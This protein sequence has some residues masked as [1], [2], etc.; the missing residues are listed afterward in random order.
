MVA[1]KLSAT[2]LSQ[3]SPLRPTERT[4]P[5]ARA[6]SAKSPLVYWVNSI[7]RRNTSTMEVPMGRPAGWMKELTGR[8][9]MKSPGAP[10]L[11]REVEQQFW[12]QIATGITT[13]A[14]ASTVGVSPAVGARWFRHRGGMP[15][16]LSPTTGRYLSF[17]EREEIAILRAQGAGIRE[18][19]R[20]LGR[21]PSTISREL[22]RNAAT[23]CGSS[24]TEH[25]WLNGRPS[26]WPS[27]QRLRSS[28]PTGRCATTCR[29]GLLVGSTARTGLLLKV[30]PL[31]LGRAE[32]SHTE[33]IVAG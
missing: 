1:K 17:H 15:I 8:S 13:D 27:V 28:S 29:N 10:S 5:L 21:A 3:H 6:N 11:R 14:A 7:G 16:D 26:S 31:H 12:R 2:A 22:R 32:A 23:R 4:T 9:P 20:Q 30:P 25:Q 19:G 18:I 24:N 33:R